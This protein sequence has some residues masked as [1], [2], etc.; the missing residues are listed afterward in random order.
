M[1]S[2]AER[3][4]GHTTPAEPAGRR[5]GRID[6]LYTNIGRGHPFYLDGIIECLPHER[7]GTV[8]D[9]FATTGG[10]ARRLWEVARLVYHAAGN[11]GLYSSLYNRYRRRSDYNRAGLLSRTMGRPLRRIYRA[12]PDPLVIAHP[13]LVSMLNGKAGLVYQHGEVTAPR[14]S[15]VM[16]R[17]HVLVPLASTADAFSAA[18]IPKRRLFVSGLCIE[19]AL[20][21]RAEQARDARL[22]RLAGHGPLCGAFFSSGAEPRE[23]RE[24]LAAAALSAVRAG[25]RAIVFARRS[26]KL[27]AR[28]SQEFGVA[29]R[30]LQRASSLDEL[31]SGDS[32]A[33]LCLGGDR[34]ELDG[35]TARLFERFDYLVAPA[36]ERTNWALGLGLP[37]F[38]VDPPL[39]SYS[40]L[41]S[42][43]SQAAS[44][45]TV[46][47]SRA[48]ASELGALVGA[49]RA[50][51][52]L[53]RMAEA[54]WR[55][56][57][58]RGFFRIA[59]FLQAL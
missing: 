47:G 11:G 6:F 29:G 36:H 18:G 23:H 2:A 26:G 15:L 40:P 45:A 46:L 53:E 20:V 3:P 32:E 25:G 12:N 13:L 1:H 58:I 31:P 9:V 10:T 22:T 57:E 28:V 41:N 14:E 48:A 59:E 38:I 56:F 55:R 4:T 44:V 8:T 17:H 42:E 24:R 27:A 21:E 7:L 16:G 43:F 35:F 33:L 54:G 52:A 34:R 49:L 19:P 30:D 5:S 51:G 37:M 50:D 39:G